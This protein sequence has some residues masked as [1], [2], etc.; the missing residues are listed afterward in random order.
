MSALAPKVLGGI[1][2]A[3]RRGAGEQHAGDGR[4]QTVAPYAVQR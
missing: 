4:A 3:Q 1:D 2:I